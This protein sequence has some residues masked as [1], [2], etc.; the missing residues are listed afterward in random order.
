[1]SNMFHV[2]NSQ[3][4]KFSLINRK[5]LKKR[6]LFRDYINNYDNATLGRA[7]KYF[8]GPY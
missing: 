5:Y 8:Y 2:R 6:L 7:V 4:L 1:M 3:I